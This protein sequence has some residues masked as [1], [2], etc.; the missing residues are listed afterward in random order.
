[1]MSRVRFIHVTGLFARRG[2]PLAMMVSVDGFLI[3]LACCNAHFY[4]REEASI[5][6]SSRGVNTDMTLEP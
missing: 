1:M 6:T 4:L 5:A 2:R 3:T